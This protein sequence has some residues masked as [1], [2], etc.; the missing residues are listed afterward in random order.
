MS[1]KSFPKTADLLRQKRGEDEYAGNRV[2][3]GVTPRRGQEE[4]NTLP[5]AP[6]CWA[7]RTH[8]GQMKG[9]FAFIWYTS[10]FPSLGAWEG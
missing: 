3:T 9:K 10:H 7:M 4:K 5:D 1:L 2:E 6:L 8:T